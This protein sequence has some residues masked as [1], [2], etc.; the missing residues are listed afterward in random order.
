MD[1]KDAPSIEG[2]GDFEG[3]GLWRDDGAW[4]DGN[5]GPPRVNGTSRTPDLTAEV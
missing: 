3:A 4:S 5:D 2:E 1:D